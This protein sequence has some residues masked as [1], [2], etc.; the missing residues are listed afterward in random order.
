M[1]I[2]CIKEINVEPCIHASKRN[3]IEN[4]KKA[5]TK[6]KKSYPSMPFTSEQSGKYHLQV[7]HGNKKTLNSFNNTNKKLAWNTTLHRGITSEVR[8]S[9]KPAQ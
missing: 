6:K 3:A 9:K 2:L 5:S 1:L 4:I 7:F 8:F